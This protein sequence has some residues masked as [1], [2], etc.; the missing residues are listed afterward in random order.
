MQI[1][2]TRFPVRIF[3]M[4]TVAMVT[5]IPVINKVTMDTITTDFR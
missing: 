2:T 1:A 4:L 3:C 5:K